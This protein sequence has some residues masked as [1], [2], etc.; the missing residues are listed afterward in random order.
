MRNTLPST[1]RAA[2]ISILVVSTAPAEVKLAPIFGSDMVLQRDKP[3][4]VWGRADAGEKIT[5]AFAGQSKSTTAAN[6]GTWRVSLEHLKTSADPQT[7]TV[8][9]TNKI[10][11]TNVLVGEV[12]VCSGQSNMDW[13]LPESANGEQATAA[14]N[15][16]QLRLYFVPRRMRSKGN[17]LD[18]S[19]WR[20]CTPDSVKMF[21]AVG[22][23][24][25]IELQK[26][27]NVPVGLIH[28]SWGGTPAEAWTPLE[29]LTTRD[30]LRPIV[31]RENGYAAVRSELQPKFDAD[32]K[33]W[34][35]DSAKAK[36]EG[37][38]P[39]SRPAMPPALRMHWVPGA[40]WD[41]MLEPVVPFAIRGALWYQGESNADRA[42]QYRVLLPTM[43]KAWRDKWG[44][45]DFP[46][47]IVQLTNY[48][49]EKSEPQDSEWPHLR[50]AQLN[51]YKTVPNTGLIV[52]M[53]LGEARDIHP[54]N[55]LDVGKRSALWALHDVYGQKVG[56]SGPIYESSRIIDNRIVVKFKEVGD[57]LKL[58]DGDKLDEFIIAG[59]DKVW[60]WAQA[61]IVSK[62]EID[63]WSADVPAPKAAR[64][65][66][67][68][69][70]HHP[71]LT[72]ST[73]LPASPFRTDDWP[74]PTDGKR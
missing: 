35:E 69:N 72:N 4:P 8:S 64:F 10:E 58:N 62:D 28:S 6:D 29:Y 24:F 40:L 11:L 3:V 66:W 43:I 48:M 33:K 30:E 5:V 70:P 67:A 47:G 65:A 57:G 7:L 25:G 20:P 59:E 19:L 73:G 9:G 53:G 49:A 36:S 52:I 22:Y 1:F 37:R 26:A 54:K 14:A 51:T 50:D 12:W 41:G 17:D 45:G 44:Q 21:S 31:E 13:K 2:L 68:D 63:V 56:K 38:Q 34:E 39:A 46:F 18:G 23:Y 61:K 60:H 55:K 15:H 74:G 16:P 27:L 42:Q 32:M 71:N